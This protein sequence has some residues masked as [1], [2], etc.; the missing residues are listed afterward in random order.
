MRNL[1]LAVA[2]FVLFAG[3]VVSYPSFADND[4]A[5]LGAVAALLIA[6]LVAIILS[7]RG[8]PGRNNDAP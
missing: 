5:V 4:L 3:V 7:G 6:G 8:Q 2:F 1:L